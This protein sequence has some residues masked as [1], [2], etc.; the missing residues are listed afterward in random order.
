M[1]VAPAHAILA[2]TCACSLKLAAAYHHRGHDAHHAPTCRPAAHIVYTSFERAEPYMLA[3]RYHTSRA[4]AGRATV[5]HV[6][7][8]NTGTDYAQRRPHEPDLGTDAAVV[9]HTVDLAR[10]SGY[11]D[12][13]QHYLHSSTNGRDYEMLCMARFLALRDFCK[14][15][16]IDVFMHV[17]GDIA[18]FD[19]TLLD[20]AC[21]PHNHTAWY[22]ADASTFLSTLTCREVDAFAT[23]LL[24]F[25][26][27][28][29]R[30]D[31]VA[32]IVTHGDPVDDDKRAAINQRIPEYAA[33]GLPPHHVSDMHLL[34]AFLAA[35]LTDY[36]PAPYVYITA[37][38]AAN[39]LVPLGNVRDLFG[40]ALRERLCR[41]AATFDAHVRISATEQTY[42]AT[43]GTWH[44]LHGGHFQGIECKQHLVR[45]LGKW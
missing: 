19:A 9:A 34:A 12:F 29:N 23:F 38:H 8:V 11:A 42:K 44:K 28:A 1:L 22:Y 3:A 31:V 14:A 41:D 15:H 6:N 27:R 16:A 5:H 32:D 40:G 33:A 30:A 25:Y 18:L 17:D 45:T 39:A 2:L 4:V 35:G 43:D 10:V 26:V 20:T 36:R 37:Q 13:H 7:I 21:I 24:K